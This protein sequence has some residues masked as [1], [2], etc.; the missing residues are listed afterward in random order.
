MR[1]QVR[2]AT[3]SEWT[4]DDPVLLQ[5]EIGYD[6]DLKI[7]RVGDG[8]TAWSELPTLGSDSG[9]GGDGGENLPDGGNTG[10]VLTR[11][12][13]GGAGW[14]AVPKELPA[15]GTTGQVLTI[16]SGGAVGWATISGG[17]EGGGSVPIIDENE[18]LPAGVGP[19]N[20]IVRRIST[21][22][23]LAIGPDGVFQVNND[24]SLTDLGVEM[25]SGIDIINVASDGADTVLMLT[26]TGALYRWT[27]G[28]L[29]LVPDLTLDG[30]CWSDGLSKFVSL[31]YD[32]TE[33]VYE[34]SFALSEDGETWTDVGSFSDSAFAPRESSLP[35]WV[36]GARF[37]GAGSL[38]QIPGSEQLAVLYGNPNWGNPGKGY[39]TSADAE[40]WSHVT[41]P[42]T[43]S[44]ADAQA[45]TY[46]PD[47]S[48][49]VGGG[50][51]ADACLWRSTDDGATW[52]KAS[53]QGGATWV[54]IDLAATPDRLYVSSVKASGGGARTDVVYFDGINYSQILDR[55]YGD[56]SSNIDGDII[57]G[58]VLDPLYVNGDTVLGIT[59]GDGKL[60]SSATQESTDVGNLSGIT[61]RATASYELRL[62]TGTGEVVI[63]PLD[64]DDSGAT[65]GRV[66]V[67]AQDDPL[68]AGTAAGSLVV[69]PAAYSMLMCAY[70][71]VYGSDGSDNAPTLLSSSGGDVDFSGLERFFMAAVDQLVVAIALSSDGYRGNIARSVNGGPFK[72]V[73][74]SAYNPIGIVSDGSQL[75]M[76]QEYYDDE[77]S[78][79]VGFQMLTSTDGLTWTAGSTI[80][81]EAAS[82][83]GVIRRFYFDAGLYVLCGGGTEI[84]VSADAETWT[85][86][87]TGHTPVDV[88]NTE[89]VFILATKD[90]VYV[91]L[92]E[93]Y[94]NWGAGYSD[95]GDIFCVGSDGY[96]TYVGTSKGLVGGYDGTLIPGVPPTLSIYIDPD[97]EDGALLCGTTTGAVY[98][99]GWDEYA[100]AMTTTRLIDGAL[101]GDDPGP[102]SFMSHSF[103]SGFVVNQVQGDASTEL[104][105][106]PR[107]PFKTLLNRVL[108]TSSYA[109]PQVASPGQVLSH[110]GKSA[111]WADPLAVVSRLPEQPSADKYALWVPRPRPAQLVGIGRNADSEDRLAVFLDDDWQID[112]PDSY[113]PGSPY[114]FSPSRNELVS[115][116]SDISFSG[117]YGQTWN[118]MRQPLL[119]DYVVEQAV[120]AESLQMFIMLVEP[121]SGDD[122]YI[123]TSP[124]GV[125][126]S[127][128]V[129]LADSSGVTELTWVEELGIAIVFLDRHLFTSADGKVWTDRGNIANPS[130]VSE[131][132]WC[133]SLSLVVAFGNPGTNGAGGPPGYAVSSDGITWTDG[134]GGNLN[135]LSTTWSEARGELLYVDFINQGLV[136]K[137]TDALSFTQVADL[138]SLASGT[139]IR[140]LHWSPTANRY[141]LTNFDDD[142][143]LS[144][145]DGVTWNPES[146]VS[147]VG[148]QVWID[149]PSA[150]TTGLFYSDGSTWHSV[151]S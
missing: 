5:G 36:S 35:G 11:L 123:W 55:G 79:L 4:T 22:Q 120:W 42:D 76:A 82:G 14:S 63:G 6:T 149:I 15:G 139:A 148:V 103:T 150:N 71:G 113:L 1:I 151:G 133:G 141:L 146:D 57:G 23:P 136:W 84:A 26:A 125:S 96:D 86:A 66:P 129:Y 112:T 142:Y 47:D 70:G 46:L 140:N 7:A 13:G 132:L 52:A 144:S 105:Y 83:D 38:R 73:Q 40:T 59:S 74:T 131:V 108:E 97:D 117:D 65:G 87:D 145:T 94:T 27:G 69:R 138:S 95:I 114:A 34:F 111:K 128:P 134:E 116:N 37:R 21:M 9:E 68:P 29:E 75:I 44:Q 91:A 41:G 127:E 137:S 25:P 124:D 51:Y 90:T 122:H 109:V 77:T 60:W 49:L 81:M 43:G 99:V 115:F 19:G 93:T 67:L 16:G 143:V 101:S 106:P 28:T 72:Y 98:R 32:G 39:Y 18:T 58:E 80:T 30:V 8:A 12:E 119:D 102:V 50:W 118:I 61:G 48:L 85:V 20:L 64:A 147:D 56:Q 78:E 2:R 121:W 110:D 130:Q 100:E 17:G 45:I 88:L 62:V 126:F 135:S 89:N 3:T 54:V 31:T 10:D 33:D 92:D 107:T 53:S 104:Q 24:G